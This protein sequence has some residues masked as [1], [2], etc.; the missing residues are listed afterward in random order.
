[1]PDIGSVLIRQRVRLREIADVLTRYGFAGLADRARDAGDD[2]RAERITRMADPDLADLSTGERLRGVLTEL[3]T[4]WVKLGQML[5]LRSDVVGPE[6]AE[7]L[8]LL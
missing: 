4:T 5:S 2:R 3:G 1:M 8:T 7:S 6:V